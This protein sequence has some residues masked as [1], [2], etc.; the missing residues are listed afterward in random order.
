MSAQTEQ[1]IFHIHVYL[2]VWCQSVQ[3][4][5]IHSFNDLKLILF[6]FNFDWSRKK[7]LA[8]S[9]G[10][11]LYKENISDQQYTPKNFSS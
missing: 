4:H 11:N 9:A 5:G 1:P 3:L 2:E 7:I 8:K 10:T 6:R